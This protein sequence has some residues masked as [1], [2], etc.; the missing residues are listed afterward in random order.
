MNNSLVDQISL[1]NKNELDNSKWI[2]FFQHCDNYFQEKHFHNVH[3]I[4][5]YKKKLL[6]ITK[7][8]PVNYVYYEP[9]L[10]NLGQHT[11]YYPKMVS[12]PP[13][14]LSSPPPPPGLTKQKPTKHIDFELHTFQDLLNLLEKEPYEEEF[15]YNINLEALHKVKPELE[16]INKMIGLEEFKDELLNQLLYFSQD[17]H[18]GQHGDYMHTVLYGPPGTGKTEIA[19]LLGTMYSKVGLLSKNIFRKVCRNDLIAGYLGQTALKTKKVVEETLGGC[20]FIDEAYSLG[21]DYEGDSFSRECIDVLCESL[22]AYKN[23]W[24]VIIAGYEDRLQSSFFQAN[25]GLKS[26]FI[27]KFHLQDYNE[28]QL[29]H[30]FMKK[31]EE[32]EWM[33]SFNEEFLEQWIGKYK[34]NFIHYGRD[35]EQLLS[36]CKIVHGRRIYG[37]T[38]HAKKELNEEDLKKGFE[39][40]KLNSL[41]KEN[42]PP[43]GMYL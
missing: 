9:S 42:G 8:S 26:R 12:N 17:L 6:E 19:M 21:N 25:Q 11:F 39:K 35:M 30:I 40:F 23:D 18:K 7:Y 4:G 10:I 32:N 38:Q 36:Y 43:M 1:Y 15:D 13:S 29:A 41:H 22:S 5:E 3:Y 14:P 20:L 34:K 33:T 37:K 27:W 2:Q 31:V 28:K 24:M 16:K